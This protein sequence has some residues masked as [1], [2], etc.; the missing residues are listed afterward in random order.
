MLRAERV[1]T[2]ALAAPFTGISWP[3]LIAAA[4]FIALSSR[5][6]LLTDADTY[7]HMATG[8]WILEHGAIPAVDVFSHT[9]QGSRWTAHE[10]LSEVLFAGGFKLAGWTGVLCLTAAATALALAMLARF[11]LRHL[12]PIYV[13]VVV[14]LC[15]SLLAPHLLARP[16]V[17]IA[18]VMVAWAIGMADAREAGSAPRLWLRSS[19]RCGPTCTRASW[20]GS[21]SR[22]L[23]PLKRYW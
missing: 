6:E 13:L 9:M 2:A 14:A 12:E 10:W 16:H 3:L 8:R 1:G 20:S 23:L 15:A 21:H 7:W 19:W 22:V 4:A 5:P 11:L 17:L 18:P